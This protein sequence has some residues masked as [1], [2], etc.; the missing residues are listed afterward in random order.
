[1]RLSF[2]LSVSVPVMLMGCAGTSA[3][4]PPGGL[5]FG[6][7]SVPAATYETGDSLEISVESPMGA[8][9]MNMD[10]AMTLAMSFERTSE[11]V[12]VTADI[13]K[14]AGAMSNPMAG[15]VSVD[16]GDVSGPLVFVVAPSGAVEVTAS[17]TVAGAGAQLGVFAGKAQ[18]F[19]PRFPDGPV[20]PGASWIDTVS[21]SGDEGGAAF[22]SSTAYTYTM[23]G[24]TVVG[25]TSLVRIAVVGDVETTVNTSQGGMDIEQSLTGTTTGHFLWDAERGLLYS[26]DMQRDLT[27]VVNVPGMGLPPMA[28]KA[29]GPANTRLVN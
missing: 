27:G 13:E 14:L 9:V 12:Q 11:G 7:P 2:L 6:V 28:L 22:S 25:G 5:S 29:S 20:E 17:P 8:M 16:E 26:A 15:N 1:M 24:D 18:E 23:A 3:P 21:W 4:A 19:F 10:A